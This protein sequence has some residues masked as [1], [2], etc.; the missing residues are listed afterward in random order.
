M[1]LLIAVPTMDNVPVEFLK[2]LVGLIED[3]QTEGVDY[4]VL[5]ENG[6]LVYMARDRLASVA[7][8]GDYT[9]VLWLDSDMV[10]E[11]SLLEDLSFSGKPFV[12]GIAHAR[13]AP[14]N[15]CLF[16][17]IHLDTLTRWRAKDYPSET[18]EVAGCGFACVLMEADILRD[19][20][21]VCDTCFTPFPKYGEDLSFCKRATALGYKLYAEP[22]VRLGH[23]GRY[24]IYPEE[25]EKYLGTAISN[26]EELRRKNIGN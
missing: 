16:K 1:K 26:I 21:K 24:A 13:R 4:E 25:E 11:P 7:I 22:T 10:F 6:T 15:S 18:F 2:S 12:T 9:H 8:L 14:F 20:Q 17:D 19:V 23:V 3:L 5:I